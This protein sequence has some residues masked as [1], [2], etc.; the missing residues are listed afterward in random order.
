MLLGPELDW[1]CYENAMKMYY[2]WYIQKSKMLQ[3]YY[4]NITF[5]ILIPIL[6]N[7]GQ[8][9]PFQIIFDVVN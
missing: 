6:M 5:F 8:I 3:K 1:K 2:F 4:K 9:S 7:F